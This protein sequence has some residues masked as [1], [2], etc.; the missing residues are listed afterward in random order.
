MSKY[1]NHE[2]E[3]AVLDVISSFIAAMN[4]P[5]RFEEARKLVFE[6]GI[7][8]VSWSVHGNFQHSLSQ[9]IDVS[10]SCE[11]EGKTDPGAYKLIRSDPTPEVYICDQIAAVWAVLERTAPNNSVL[12]RSYTIF[13][14][15]KPDSSWKVSGLM[16]SHPDASTPL[17][18][19]EKEITP[20]IERLMH[21]AEEGFK[22]RGIDN[23]DDWALP[24]TRFVRHKLPDAPTGALVADAVQ[25]MT[26]WAASLPVD[27]KW[28]EEFEDR[29]VRIAGDTGFVWMRFTTFLN[30]Q[31]QSTGIDV[32]GLHRQDGKWLFSGTQTL[33]LAAGGQ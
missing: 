9:A 21:F 29:I 24:G 11:K 31:P 18:P 3:P 22:A 17:P 2:E 28:T 6:P 16:H 33:S 14:L 13:F 23:L 7:H 1:I 19:V 32:L 20:G 27:T 25:Q 5:P 12:F 26:G 15:V 8:F 10:E 4:P 30:G